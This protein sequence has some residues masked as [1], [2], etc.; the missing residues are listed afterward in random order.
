MNRL[1]HWIKRLLLTCICAAPFAVSAPATAQDDNPIAK[2]LLGQF[3]ALQKYPEAC[4]FRLNQHFPLPYFTGWLSDGHVQGIARSPRPGNPFIYVSVAGKTDSAEPDGWITVV[5]M[6]SR[7]ILGERFRSN[8]IGYEADGVTNYIT[9]YTYPPFNDAPIGRFTFD[10]STG[11][12]NPL[13]WKWRHVG[14]LCIIG[15]ILVVPLEERQPGNTFSF[16]S[17]V[18]FLDISDPANPTPLSI[19]GF[20]D[21]KAGTVA[22]ARLADQTYLMLV[23][24]IDGGA[25]LVGYVTS[26]TS[27]RDPALAWAQGFR[28]SQSTNNWGSASYEWPWN[29]NGGQGATCPGSD[30]HQAYAFIRSDDN[31]LYLAGTTRRQSC[32]S[33][34]YLGTDQADLFEV[35]ITGSPVNF[36]RLIHRVTKVFDFNEDVSGYKANFIAGGGF[37]VSPSGSL[38]LYGSPHGWGNEPD[39]TPGGPEQQG[40][41][42]MQ[43]VEIRPWFVNAVANPGPGSAYAEFYIDQDYEGR[44]I[45]MDFQDRNL[46]AWTTFF[47]NIDDF[48]DKAHSIS[49]CIPSTIALSCWSNANGSGSPFALFNL[50]RFTGNADLDD[51]GDSFSSLSFSGSLSDNVWV[52]TP[53]SGQLSQSGIFSAPTFTINGG[54]SQCVG[55]VNKIFVE[56]GFYNE[57]VTFVKPMQVIASPGSVVIGASN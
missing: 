16:E 27:L 38:I 54:L 10:G 12:G 19:H 14:N 44:S 26:S 23:G 53:R 6:A 33:P 48:N 5:H 13:W 20:S 29:N 32:G 51:L 18:A 39:F 34:F 17:A 43:F 2:N 45:V 1:T 52:G 8:R 56:A 57:R 7:D 11:T 55:P 35:V 40:P 50:S 47:G 25:T 4:G 15:D 21:E 41:D 46:E 42:F 49:Y 31:R 3:G 22:V 28:W 37:H 9:R 36:M 24:G 30:A